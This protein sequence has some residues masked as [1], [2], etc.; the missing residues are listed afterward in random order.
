M[1]ITEGKDKKKRKVVKGRGCEA[2]GRRR[3]Y[4]I[5]GAGGPKKCTPREEKHFDGGRKKTKRH[6]F[7]LP[8]GGGKAMNLKGK[9]RG[10]T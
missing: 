8:W 7:N 9:K 5:S 4:L 10:K 6:P 2:S 3:A 1:T